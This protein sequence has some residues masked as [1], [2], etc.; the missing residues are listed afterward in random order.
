[1]RPSGTREEPTIEFRRSRS[2]HPGLCVGGLP[3]HAAHV[4]A[5]EGD[6]PVGDEGSVLDLYVVR[7]RA[8]TLDNVHR[9]PHLSRCQRVAVGGPRHGNGR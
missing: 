7:C 4:A 2:R 1:M 8:R 5:S 3:G 6:L 9:S